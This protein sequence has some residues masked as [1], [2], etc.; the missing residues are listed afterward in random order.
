MA[1]K[2]ICWSLAFSDV[3]YD[4]SHIVQPVSWYGSVP[5]NS[6]NTMGIYSAYHFLRRTYQPE[7]LANITNISWE[8]AATLPLACAIRWLQMGFYKHGTSITQSYV[9]YSQLFHILYGFMMG[10]FPNQWP[11]QL[12]LGSWVPNQLPG[13]HIFPVPCGLPYFPVHGIR[14]AAQ[15][16]ERGW[17]HADL[18]MQWLGPWRMST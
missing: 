1:K 15:L 9:V 4:A 16:H 2:R 7:K 14:C 11:P 12:S 8:Y 5:K 3:C 6:L 13:T 18:Q 10:Y 17:W